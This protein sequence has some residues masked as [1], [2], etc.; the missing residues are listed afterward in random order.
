MTKRRDS[1][2]AT[3]KFDS[4]RFCPKTDSNTK[5]AAVEALFSPAVSVFIHGPGLR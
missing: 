4:A 5:P 3:L 2:N 1:C